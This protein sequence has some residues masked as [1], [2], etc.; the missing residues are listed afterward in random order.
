MLMPTVKEAADRDHNRHREK[1]GNMGIVCSIPFKTFEGISVFQ[2]EVIRPTLNCYSRWVL[3]CFPL[4]P[5]IHK[6]MLRREKEIHG[7]NPGS[8]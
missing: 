1:P 8:S 6:A 2:N 4:L 7:K 5:D 3:K